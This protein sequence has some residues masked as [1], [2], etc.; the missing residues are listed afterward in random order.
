MLKNRDGFISKRYRQP[1][2]Y[3]MIFTD[4]VAVY[5]H[6]ETGEEYHIELNSYFLN[7]DCAREVSVLI[8]C[9]DCRRQIGPRHK[10]IKEAVG[11]LERIFQ[12]SATPEKPQEKSA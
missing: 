12:K 4:W 3:R 10:T 9:E 2:Q 11:A 1:E 8:Q 7:R 6:P 5:R